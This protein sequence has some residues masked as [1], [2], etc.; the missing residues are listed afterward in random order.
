MISTLA[1]I[2]IVDHA[3]RAKDREII[4]YM[5]GFAKHGVF[6][7]LDVCELPIIGSD[8]RVEVAG[9]MGDKTHEYS[10]AMLELLKQ[11]ILYYIN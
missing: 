1:T 6:Y 7:V 2:K 11:V 5:T 9:Q 3:I 8:S 4:G 10:W